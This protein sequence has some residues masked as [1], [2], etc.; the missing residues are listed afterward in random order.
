MGKSKKLP[1]II[2]L[3]RKLREI[4]KKGKTIFIWIFEILAR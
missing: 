1:A 3:S 4:V 2:L